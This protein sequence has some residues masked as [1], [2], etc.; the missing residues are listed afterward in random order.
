[1]SEAAIRSNRG[2]IYQS[3]VAFDWLLTVLSDPNYH[4]LEVD[5][6]LHSVD[7]VVVG[8]ADGTQIACQCKKNQVH[9]KAW[10]IADLSDELPKAF[11]FLSNNQ[12]G[13]VRFYSRNNFG[14]L[15]KLREHSST[16]YDD[17]SYRASLSKEHKVT[18]K[19]LSTL[20]SKASSSLSAFEFLRRT[21]FITTNE[22]DRMEALLLHY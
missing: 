4:W 14:A 3:L 17:V 19:G 10:S 13:E 6:I 21:E 22:L 1:M 2:D 7:D 12:N 8:R 9:F 16:Q 20:L 18:D 11:S 5:S 15:A